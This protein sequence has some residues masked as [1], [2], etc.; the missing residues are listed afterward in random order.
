MPES[1]TVVYRSYSSNYGTVLITVQQYQVRDRYV[2]SYCTVGG[3][4]LPVAFSGSHYCSPS[5]CFALLLT[6]EEPILGFE[7]RTEQYSENLK[8]STRYGSPVYRTVRSTV[9]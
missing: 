5:V 9:Q 2:Q 3:L 1:T 7:V 4:L 8:T 6:V